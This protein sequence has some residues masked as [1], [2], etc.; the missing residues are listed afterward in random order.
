MLTFVPV[1][2]TA[3]SV[4]PILADSAVEPLLNTWQMRRDLHERG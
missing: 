2:G 1:P 4:E 3:L